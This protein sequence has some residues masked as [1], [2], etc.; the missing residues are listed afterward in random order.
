MRLSVRA[1]RRARPEMFVNDISGAFIAPEPPATEKPPPPPPQTK[2]CALGAPASPPAGQAAKGA[3]AGGGGVSG[4]PTRDLAPKTGQRE[5]KPGRETKRPPRGPGKTRSLGWAPP[6]PGTHFA[7]QRSANPRPYL[8]PTY[9]STPPAPTHTPRSLGHASGLRDLT[10]PGLAHRR[11]E[12]A[13]AQGEAT[14]AGVEDPRGWGRGPVRD[15]VSPTQRGGAGSWD[16]SRRLSPGPSLY[17]SCSL[18]SS[19]QLAR[20]FLGPQPLGDP[21]RTG[22]LGRGP[23]LTGPAPGLP[24][25]LC[26]A[27]AGAPLPAPPSPAPG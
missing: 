23:G 4:S 11:S 18:T 19:D 20:S 3:S 5:P 10:P 6:P 7:E 26:P 25:A 1:P 8:R 17:C 14:G 27:P 22:P 15:S 9:S 24:A 2:S 12:R 16:G 21:R 13:A